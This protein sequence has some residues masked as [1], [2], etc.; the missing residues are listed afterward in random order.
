M[1]AVGPLFCCV[2]L[3]SSCGL[4]T[5]LSRNRARLVSEGVMNLFGDVQLKL[6]NTSSLLSDYWTLES[7]GNVPIFV[8]KGCYCFPS[9][10]LDI[11]MIT[12]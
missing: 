12:F 6:K 7:C 9:F 3:G 4:R 5:Q 8:P 1:Y 10:V 11:N 2:F